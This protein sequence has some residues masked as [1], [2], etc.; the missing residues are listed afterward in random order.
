MALL[1]KMPLKIIFGVD[2]QFRLETM[3][4]NHYWNDMLVKEFEEKYISL[5]KEIKKQG[6]QMKRLKVVEHRNGHN[7]HTSIGGLRCMS[8]DHLCLT[9]MK[10]DLADIANISVLTCK[11]NVRFGTDVMNG[12]GSRGKIKTLRL[13]HFDD[14]SC[15]DVLN[16]KNVIQSLNLHKT[17]KNLLVQI[18]LT[19]VTLRDNSCKWRRLLNQYCKKNIIITETM[20]IYCWN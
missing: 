3:K 20:L 19:D 18:D 12:N 1:G 15:F 7:G 6:K 4:L 10:V 9:S 16:N 2:S 14:D 5:Q 8:T 17:C 13:L 11:D